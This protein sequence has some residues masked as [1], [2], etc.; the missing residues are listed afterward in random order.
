MSI[1]YTVFSIVQRI[2]VLGR[3]KDGIPPLVPVPVAGVK[4]PQF[5][6]GARR[7]EFEAVQI[8]DGPDR[9]PSRSG[10]GEK[11]ESV[12]HVI[13]IRRDSVRPQNV[14]SA[15]LFA[16]RKTKN[17]ARRAGRDKNRGA[18]RTAEVAAFHF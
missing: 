14:L 2:I 5:G 18:V 3:D 13:A 6:P 12:E 11:G 17:P 10:G 1:L 4:D 8:R 15:L 16:D 9:H 7:Q